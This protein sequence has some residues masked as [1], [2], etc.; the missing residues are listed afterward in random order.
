MKQKSL[1]GRISHGGF[2][3]KEEMLL[4]LL[5]FNLFKTSD[6]IPLCY[7]FVPVAAKYNHH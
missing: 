3:S 6:F 5:L 4:R 7:T 2:P 1:S